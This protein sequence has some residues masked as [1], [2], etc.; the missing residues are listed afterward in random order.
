MLCHASTSRS[1]PSLAPKCTPR[2]THTHTH[3]HTHLGARTHTHTGVRACRLRMQVFRV[4]RRATDLEITDT[5]E[6][7]PKP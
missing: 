2:S 3:T 4:Q 5:K 1:R 6:L 7:N